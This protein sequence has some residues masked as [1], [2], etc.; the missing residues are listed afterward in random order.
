M[1]TG[2]GDRRHRL[3]LTA[4]RL[5]SGVNARLVRPMLTTSWV[6]MPHPFQGVHYFRGGLAVG[7]T[8]L[9]LRQESV[10]F[11]HRRFK[12]HGI[13]GRPTLNLLIENV[14]RISYRF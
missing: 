8:A 10:Q 12:L 5:N 7:I 3:E 13:K 9:S 6:S 11:L 2:L 14:D 1:D 4:S